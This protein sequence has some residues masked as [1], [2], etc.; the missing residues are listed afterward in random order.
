MKKAMGLQEFVAVFLKNSLF[1]RKTNQ[2]LAK[3][4]LFFKKSS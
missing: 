2:N 1:F 3:P 4:S